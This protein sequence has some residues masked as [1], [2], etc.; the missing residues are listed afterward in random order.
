MCILYF[1]FLNAVAILGLTLSMEEI[2][3]CCCLATAG[4][5]GPCGHSITPPPAGV[6]RRM[7][8]KRQNSWVGVRA[9]Q[10]T[11]LNSNNNT[12]RKNVKKKKK[13]D[14]D[15]ATLTVRCPV[16]SRSTINF[17]SG[18]LPHS[19]SSMTSHGIKYPIC[20]ANLGQPARLCLF[21]ASGEN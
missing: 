17:L 14:M 7:E 9:E 20:L 11:E 8:R 1:W 18:Q 3:G 4:N 15:R 10:K 6:G 2:D 16:R 13:S 21:P 19:E 12:D 5:Q